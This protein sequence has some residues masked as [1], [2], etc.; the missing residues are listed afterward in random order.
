M[1]V[2]HGLLTQLGECLGHNQ[3]VVGSSPAQTTRNKRIPKRFVRRDPFLINL[4]LRILQA[5]R[6]LTNLCLFSA[7]YFESS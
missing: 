6:K 7:C 2:A 1:I 4:V 5:L 3:D